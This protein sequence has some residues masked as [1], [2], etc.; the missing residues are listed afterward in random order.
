MEK[1]L[2]SGADAVIL[3]LEDSVGAAAKGDARFAVRNLL[4]RRPARSAPE[5]W[6]RINAMT[7]PDAALDLA[8]IVQSGPAGIGLP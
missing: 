8:T 6:V 7:S 2:E 1:A 4:R 5:L 3:D